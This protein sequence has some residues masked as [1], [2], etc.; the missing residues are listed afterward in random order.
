MPAPTAPEGKR[1]KGVGGSQIASPEDVG[2]PAQGPASLSGG[3]P[4]GQE[5]PRSSA[6]RAILVGWAYIEPGRTRG[7]RRRGGGSWLPRPSVREGGFRRCAW[8]SDR[9][10]VERQLQV[11]QDSPNDGRVGDEGDQLPRAAAV[12]ADQNVDLE[13]PFHQLRPGAPL[14]GWLLVFRV[15]T[16]CGRLVSVRCR[17]DRVPPRCRWSENAVVRE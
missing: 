10:E 4:N 17:N 9:R 15:G 11:R 16:P 3:R 2:S 13:G 7:S 6:R 12:W 14:P 5:P 8:R 1:C